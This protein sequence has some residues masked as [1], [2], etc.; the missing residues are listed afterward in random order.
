M[1]YN[2]YIYIY[3]YI[4]IYNIYILYILDCIYMCVCMLYKYYLQFWWE[5]FAKPCFWNPENVNENEA[6]GRAISREINKNMQMKINKCFPN[7][8]SS[9]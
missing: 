5:N 7:I 3:I 1:G 2:L 9:L 6:S 4:Y 8:Q